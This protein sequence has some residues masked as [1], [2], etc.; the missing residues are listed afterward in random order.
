MLIS[1]QRAFLD[2][3]ADAKFW[4]KS[5]TF[6]DSSI[7]T[8][9]FSEPKPFCCEHWFLLPASHVVT[10]AIPTKLK[11]WRLSIF[12]QRHQGGQTVLLMILQTT[13]EVHNAH[14]SWSMPRAFSI[15]FI[16]PFLP[17]K[18]HPYPRD[19]CH[20][21]HLFNQL[22]LQHLNGLLTSANSVRQRDTHV[23]NSESPPTEISYN[24]NFFW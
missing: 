3:G 7:P 23:S 1:S 4:I 2:V 21:I 18:L 11:G 13:F 9:K 14:W 16:W 24:N 8:P 15:W 12:H 10:S 5:M 19:C 17:L 22:L 6:H 20:P